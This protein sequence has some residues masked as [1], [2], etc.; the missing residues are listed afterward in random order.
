MKYKTG[1]TKD[2]KLMALEAELISDAGGHIYL[3]PW[4]LLYSTV[5]ATGPYDITHVKVDACTV[6]TNN[7]F[8]SA[9]RGFGAPQVCFAYESQMDEVARRLNLSPLEIRKKNYL[10]TGD[11]LATGRI[12]EHSVETEATAEKALK[13]LGKPSLP[14]SS[15]EKIGQG[16]ASGM[17]S[18][19]R[20]VFLHDT[21]R[22]FVSIEMDGSVT[23]KCGVQDIG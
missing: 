15:T 21:A 4:V 11:A 9:N 18:Y 5:N 23:V 8:C 10:R 14:R 2:G 22:S 7:T 12:L 13:A 1:A 6:L 16:M 19:G 3:S 20:M 17:M